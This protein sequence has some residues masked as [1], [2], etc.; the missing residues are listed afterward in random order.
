MIIHPLIVFAD[1]FVRKA[2]RDEEL[3]PAIRR[4]VQRG[5]S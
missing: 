3:L 1:E 2:D 4:I 5:R